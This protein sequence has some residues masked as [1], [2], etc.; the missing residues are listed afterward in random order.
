MTYSVDTVV[1]LRAVLKALR[2]TRGMSQSELGRLMGVNQKRIA[3]IEANPGVT[4]WSQVVR[5]IS[6]LGGRVAIDDASKAPGGKASSRPSKGSKAA[7]ASKKQ[8]N[9]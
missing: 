7:G 5:M 3:A 2:K 6:A 9:W 8:A 4:S 1:Q